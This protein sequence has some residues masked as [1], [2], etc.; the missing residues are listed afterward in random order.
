MTSNKFIIEVNTTKG[1]AR[2]VLQVYMY[3]SLCC[4]VNRIQA[5]VYPGLCFYKN[6]ADATLCC[7]ISLHLTRSC[8]QVCTLLLFM[9]TIEFIY[10]I[11]IQ[12]FFVAHTYRFFLCVPLIYCVACLNS[13]VWWLLKRLNANFSVIKQSTTYWNY[14]DT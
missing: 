1:F 7:H 13:V 12:N 9:L 3:V 5:G 11:Y 2:F 4:Y 6:F 14:F 10:T 8:S